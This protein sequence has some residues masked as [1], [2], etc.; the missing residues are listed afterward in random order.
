M[1]FK[2]SINSGP[3]HLRDFFTGGRFKKHNLFEGENFSE[4]FDEQKF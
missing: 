1:P 4:D 2:K 3:G